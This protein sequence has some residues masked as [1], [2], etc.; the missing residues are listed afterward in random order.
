M[1]M[2]QINMAAVT[3]ANQIAVWFKRD[4]L[5]LKLSVLHT[6][7]SQLNQLNILTKLSL[8]GKRRFGSGSEPW[9]NRLEEIIQI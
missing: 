9:K 6:D 4:E 1:M 3:T 5:L 8:T 2:V 7:V